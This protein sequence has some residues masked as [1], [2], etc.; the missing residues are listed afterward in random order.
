MAA[1]AAHDP[2]PGL[3]VG[4]SLARPPIFT[5]NSNEPSSCQ[6]NKGLTCHR[7][8]SGSAARQVRLHTLLVVSQ[9]GCEPQL[10]AGDW[11]A[12]VEL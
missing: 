4:L 2:G 5:S 3:C 11:R 6:L 9:P 12:A 8:Q 10:L 7:R 1:V